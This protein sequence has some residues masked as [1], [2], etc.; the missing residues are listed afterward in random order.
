MIPKIDVVG[1]FFT[2]QISRQVRELFASSLILNLALSM[3]SIFEPVFLYNFFSQT[4]N[5]RGSLMAI[6]WFYLGVYVIYFFIMPWGAKFC[7]RYG[8]ENSMALSSLFQIAFYFG[9]LALNGGYLPLLLVVFLYALAKTFYWPAYHANFAK[10]STDG[11]QGRQI[12]NLY[13]IQSIIYII[14][15]LIGGLIL[16]FFSFK[17]LFVS[18]SVLI[19]ASN[20]PMLITPE[21]FEP[22]KFAYFGFFKSWWRDFRRGRG[23]P[24]LAFGEELVLLVFWPVFMFLVANDYLSLGIISASS[25]FLTTIALLFVGRWSDRGNKK[26]LLHYGSIFYF[27]SWLFK[28]LVRTPWGIVLVDVYGR[29]SRNFISVPVTASLY[30]DAKIYSS[31]DTVMFFEISLVVGK[32]L[33]LV[34]CLVIL[35][36]FD[37]GWNVLFIFSGLVTWF[38]LF[39]NKQRTD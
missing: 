11:E 7:R 25:I 35:S 31:V 18:V 27:F 4:L 15:P 13:V 2:K 22:K 36:F 21:S 3:I 34:F 24:H 32:I 16:N 10:F 1:E 30:H 5:L 39:F 37:P 9:L 23:L 17:V 12:S 38:Y 6:A 28:I 33:A 19:L 8:Y 29:I 26:I 14:G 20:V